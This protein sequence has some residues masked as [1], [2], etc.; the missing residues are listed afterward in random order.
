MD[1][2]FLNDF[3]NALDDVR[4]KYCDINNKAEAEFNIFNIL[5]LDTKE[6]IHSSF[7][8]E[9]LNPNGSHKMG[10]KFLQLFYKE[11]G[12]EMPNSVSVI[13]E[14]S[15]Q[16]GR[17]DIYVK[18]TENDSKSLIIE[19]KIYADDQPNQLARYHEYNPKAVLV[20]LTLEGRD[21]TPNSLGRLKEDDYIKISYKQDITSWLEKCIDI[22]KEK[23]LIKET[24]YQYAVLVKQLTGQTLLEEE[25]MDVAKVA[26][27]ND[28]RMSLVFYLLQNES[29]IYKL[30][31]NR[32]WQE[33]EAAA[34]ETD[35][36]VKKEKPLIERYAVVTFETGLD[37]NIVLSPQNNNFTGIVYGI[38]SVIDKRQ[39]SIEKINEIR[40]LYKE[41]M[42]IEPMNPASFILH[43]YWQKYNKWTFKQYESVLNGTFK[44][45][46]KKLLNDLKIC[47]QK[48]K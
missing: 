17:I 16:Y 47:I 30:F 15:T 35:L 6:L 19:D 38:Q 33:I 3:F 42:N 39:L 4:K 1:E 10:N 29:A 20:Y 34:E 18:C 14:C 28:K 32:L 2:Q 9:L 46:L 31:E 25:K 11:L 8:A 5:H 44:S 41:I 43:N 27:C 24:I 37:Y 36:K 7:I 22:S 40:N 12:L 23:P 48:I 26:C 45:D 21:A 13:K